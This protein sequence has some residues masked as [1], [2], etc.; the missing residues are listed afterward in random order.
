MGFMC[1]LT[2]SSHEASNSAT[3]PSQPQIQK[4]SIAPPD[5]KEWERQPGIRLKGWRQAKELILER[6]APPRSQGSI[7]V[8]GV[9]PRAALGLRENIRDRRFV[10][11]AVEERVCPINAIGG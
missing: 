10:S 6:G 9:T 3:T 7:A 5:L 11:G 1:I 8:V 2:L 4:N